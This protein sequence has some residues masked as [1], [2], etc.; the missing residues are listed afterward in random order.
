MA[1]FNVNVG[2]TVPS[3]ATTI[4]RQVNSGQG[5]FVLGSVVQAIGAKYSVCADPVKAEFVHEDLGGNSSGQLTCV[6]GKFEA[7]TDQYDNTVAITDGAYLTVGT[8]GTAGKLIVQGSAY[9][10]AN[11]CAFA[12]GAPANGILRFQRI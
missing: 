10:G 1:W 11:A 9:N 2:L 8:G 3:S 4:S 12:I 5:P 7:E 6:I